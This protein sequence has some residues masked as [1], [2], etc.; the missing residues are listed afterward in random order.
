Y[1]SH[2]DHVAGSWFS[3]REP[4]SRGKIHDR[5]HSASQIDDAAN[6]AWRFGQRRRFCP[7]PDFAHRHNIDAELLSSHAKSDKLARPGQI[8]WALV[9]I[10]FGL[11]HLISLLLHKVVRNQ[12]QL[13]ASQPPPHRRRELKRPGRRQEWLPQRCQE[14]ADN[15]FRGF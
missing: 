5:Q 12:W 1:L 11:G 10:A 2:D 9:W 15:W 4:Q 7:T 14:H 8:G 3:R 6:E 13:R